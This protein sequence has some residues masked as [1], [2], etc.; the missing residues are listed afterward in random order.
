MTDATADLDLVQRILRESGVEQS[1]PVP[2]LAAYAQALAERVADFLH[3]RAPVVGGVFSWLAGLAPVAAWVV[4]VLV[5]ATLLVVVVK[6]VRARRA[7][8]ASPRL[9]RPSPASLRAEPVRDREGL[10]SELEQRLAAGD[11]AGGL[12]ALWWWFACSVAASV[13]VDPSWTSLELLSRCRR[14]DLVPL[15]RGLDALLYGG[16]RPGV[17]DVRQ[18]FLRLDAALP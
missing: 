11:V 14:S 15:A 4:G 12:E 1:P 9:S 5:L 6:A 13:P 2:G 16:A 7:R 10:R 17:S 3:R 8:P 18:F